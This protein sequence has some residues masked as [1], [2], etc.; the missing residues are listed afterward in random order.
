MPPSVGDR[1][2]LANA[3]VKADKVAMKNL[4]FWLPNTK[5]HLCNVV[6]YAPSFDCLVKLPISQ[7]DSYWQ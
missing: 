5:T 7:L 1:I 6:P 3:T 2:I 4:R